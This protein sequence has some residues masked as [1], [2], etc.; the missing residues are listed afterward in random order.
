MIKLM[1]AALWIS[2]ATTGAMLF[3]FQWAQAPDESANAE[4]SPAFHG[5]DYVSTDIIS[6]PVFKDGRVH[7]YFLARLVFTAEAAR[8]AQLKLPPQALLADQV[9]S[10]LYANP[11]ID[12]T[13]RQSLDVD[14]FRA[15]I[16]D[17]VN[18]RLGEDLIHEILIEQVDYLPKDQVAAAS[19]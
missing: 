3:S 13:N 4:E 11:Q 6:V 9:Y 1:V 16:R 7:G 8:L 15:G 19:Q 5:L 12:F 18:E 2:I 17:G 10:H 14:T